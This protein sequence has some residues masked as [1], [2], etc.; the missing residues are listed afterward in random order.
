MVS[1]N[2]SNLRYT[3]G[4]TPM[5]A[6]SGGAHLRDYSGRPLA[7]VT[8]SADPRIEP[9]TSRADSGSRLN[10]NWLA[11]NISGSYI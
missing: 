9:I 2:K 10:L 5:R 1:K 6:T 3:R 8:G 4:I 7:D 11:R